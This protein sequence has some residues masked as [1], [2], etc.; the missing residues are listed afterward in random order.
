MLMISA[1]GAADLRHSLPLAIAQPD[2]EV[3]VVDN[4]CRDTT[5]ELAREAGVRVLRLQKRV[6][7]CAANNVAIAATSADEVLLLNPDCFLAPDFL[8]HARPRLWEPGVGSVAPKLVRAVGVDQS[9]HQIDAAGMVLGRQRKNNLVGHGAPDGSYGRPGPCFGA[10]GAAALY[11]RETLRECALEEGP[12]DEDL[13]MYAGDVD[14]AWRAQLLGWGCAYEPTAVALHVRLYGPSTRASVPE[15]YRR[16]QFRN[17]Y[18]MMV[19]N[20]TPRGLVRDAPLIAG[21]ELLALGHVLLRERHLL[22][23]YRDAWRLL[24]A[25]V[26]KRRVVQARRRVQLPPFGIR[27]SSS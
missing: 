16:M 18:L 6:S 26:R 11:R 2:A 15:T 17:R 25:A 14:L 21:Y 19:K 9:L 4:A 8:E 27:P 10:D 20:E 13:E 12:L 23:A 5:G 24:P 22:S 7:W 3:T 1:D